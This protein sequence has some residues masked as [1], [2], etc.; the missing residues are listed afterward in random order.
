M[1]F[2][3]TKKVFFEKMDERGL[4]GLIVTGSMGSGKSAYA[5]KLL[6]Q[7]CGKL[8]V[9]ERADGIKDLILEEPN[10]D[11]WEKWLVFPPEDFAAKLEEAAS[12]EKPFPCL[13]W[14]DAGAWANK[15]I[16]YTPVA[17]RIANWFNT[18]RMSFS[19]MVFTTPDED[20]LFTGIRNL[21]DNHLGKVAKVTGNPSDRWVRR[22]TVY[23]RW[24]SIDGRKRGVRRIYVDRYVCRLPDAVYES[25]RLVRKEYTKMLVDMIKRDMDE[26]RAKRS[27]YFESFLKMVKSRGYEDGAATV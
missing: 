25:Y 6:A 23:Q 18:G 1:V 21:R 9:E 3:T 10:W 11:A 15:Y 26:D 4:F 8:K 20:D 2:V 24:K 5:I 27:L 12:A 14:D 13:V 16:W 19:C 7:L 17:Q 22:N